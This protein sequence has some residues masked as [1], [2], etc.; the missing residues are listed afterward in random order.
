MPENPAYAYFLDVIGSGNEE[1]TFVYMKH[2]ADEDSRRRWLES[3][4]DYEMPAHEEPPY[5]RDKHL[6]K[7]PF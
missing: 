6:P 7:A 3:F 2:Y 4:P 5:D 1:D